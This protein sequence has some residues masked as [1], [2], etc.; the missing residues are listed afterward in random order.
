MDFVIGDV[1]GISGAVAQT[2]LCQMSYE[3]QQCS[4]HGILAEPFVT[5]PIDEPVP[6][7]R[8]YFPNNAK[9]L[10]SR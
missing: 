1:A 4:W 9:L 6:Y 10:L 8:R 5:Y 7:L 3:L 2:A